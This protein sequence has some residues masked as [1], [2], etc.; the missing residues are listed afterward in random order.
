MVGIALNRFTKLAYQ[1]DKAAPKRG[2]ATADVLRSYLG[3]LCRGK[4]DFAAIHPFFEEDEFFRHSL[5]PTKV[6]S[7]KTL[8]Q[9]LDEFAEILRIMVDAGMVEFLKKSQAQ[10]TPLGT[11]NM[12]ED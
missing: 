7:P 6:P 4:S 1:T 2:I 3:L 8:R 10:L 5:G 12:A 9:R 11:D